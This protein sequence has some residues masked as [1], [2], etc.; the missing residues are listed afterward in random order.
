MPRV[1]QISLAALGTAALLCASI[2]PA[3]AAGPL[4]LAPFALGHVIGA[5]ARLATLPLAVASAALSESQP[6]EYPGAP[7]YGGSAGY[8]ARP[9]YYARAPAYYTAPQVYYRPDLSYP[10][11]LS[12]PYEQSRG[13]YAPRARYSGSYGPQS[14][15]RSRGF[16]Y[17]R[18]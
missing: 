18:R 6:A 17:R 10:R 4:L 9:N 12:R 3:E 5:A 7:A 2:R 13:Y 15:Y 16:A 11:P 8:Y 14:S 1:S